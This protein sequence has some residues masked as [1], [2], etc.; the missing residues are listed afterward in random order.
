MKKYRLYVGSLL[1]VASGLASA[2]Y[3]QVPYVIKGGTIKASGVT[4]N[5]WLVKEGVYRVYL[6][7]DKHFTYSCKDN[8]VIY[9]IGKGNKAKVFNSLTTLRRNV[10]IQVNEDKVEKPSLP[11]FK[12]FVQAIN[13]PDR[14][15]ILH[16][17]KD[18]WELT[19]QHLE[20]VDLCIK[21]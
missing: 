9:V 20:N 7:N 2:E 11:D 3:I 14:K 5:Y 16:Y 4:N 21:E 17:G 1:V 15:A 12:A 10:T 18:I 6:P 13:K 8:K 19:N